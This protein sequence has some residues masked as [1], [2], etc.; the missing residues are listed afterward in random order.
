MVTSNSNSVANRFGYGGKELGDEL[1]LNWHDFGARNYDQALGRWMNIDPVTHFNLSTYTA[2][3]NNPVYF[4]DPSG[5]TTVSSITDAWNA[6]SENGSSTWNSNGEGGLCNDCPQEG[7]TKP[8]SSYNSY[9]GEYENGR[10]L[11]Y[12]RGGLDNRLGTTEEGWYEEGAYYE[13]FRETIR[14]IG[15]GKASIE[16]LQK[17]SFTDDVLEA[18]LGWALQAYDYYGGEVP[19]ARGNID[20]MGFDSPIF[21]LA[22]LRVV[23]AAFLRTNT[24]EA[25]PALRAAYE[26]EVKGLSSLADKMKAGGSSS[27]EIARHMHGLRR[28]L[29][30]RY[31]SLTPDELLQTIYKRNIEKYG[32]K[33][34]PTIDYLRQ[35]GKSWEDIINSAIRSGGKDINFKK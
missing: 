5:T 29:G 21:I 34:G 14:G 19:L 1:S 24:V 33:L 9:L 13:L 35:R 15:Q 31:K 16:S 2:F 26:A 25:V 27:E 20:A 11:Y 6:T 4:A 18:M 23:G 3:D 7:Q 22:S 8:A 32:D 10:L 28:E 12:H 30:A 17:Y